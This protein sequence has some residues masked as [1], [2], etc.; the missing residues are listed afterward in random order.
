MCLQEF[1]GDL[2][3]FIHADFK[4]KVAVRVLHRKVREDFD[5]LM[6]VGALLQFIRQAMKIIQREIN[7][8]LPKRVLA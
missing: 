7:D 6:R 1:R 5:D 4:R 8:Q 3:R 2:A